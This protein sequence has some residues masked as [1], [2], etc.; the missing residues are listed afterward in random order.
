MRKDKNLD[1]KDK[2]AEDLVKDTEDVNLRLK[3]QLNTRNALNRDMNLCEQNIQRLQGILAYLN[4]KLVS[5]S[6]DETEIET[7]VESKIKKVE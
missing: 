5:L 1:Y 2:L 6:E 4:N 3:K 7:K